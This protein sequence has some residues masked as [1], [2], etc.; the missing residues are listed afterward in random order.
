MRDGR[1]WVLFLTSL[2]VVMPVGRL[3][4]RRALAGGLT[5]AVLWEL[6]RDLLVWYFSHLSYKPS[7]IE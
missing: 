2:Y 3:A 1:G 5:A 6:G 7:Q 4:L